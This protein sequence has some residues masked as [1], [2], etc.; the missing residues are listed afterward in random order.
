MAELDIGLVAYSPLGRSFLTET[1][2]VGSLGPTD[3][4]A[5]SERF[6]GAV[7]SKPTR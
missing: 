4:R 3:F 1:V 7:G 5:N 2:D 6:H